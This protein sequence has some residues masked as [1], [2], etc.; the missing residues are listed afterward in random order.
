MKTTTLVCAAL[1]AVLSTAAQAQS[2]GPSDPARAD[3]TDPNSAP[4]ARTIHHPQAA[5]THHRHSAW[6]RTSGW[7]AGGDAFASGA[8]ESYAAARPWGVGWGGMDSNRYQ[9]G[10]TGSPVAAG[11]LRGSTDRSDPS[12]PYAS[13]PYGDGEVWTNR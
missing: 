8:R 7:S 13:G 3:T 12:S 11:S 9:S 10:G 4:T 5:R 6:H 1:L 2:Y